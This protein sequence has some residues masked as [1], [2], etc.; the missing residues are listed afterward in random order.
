MS[1]LGIY[2]PEMVSPQTP[3]LTSDTVLSYFNPHK[4]ATIIV[5][6]SPVTLVLVLFFAKTTM[7][8]PMQVVLS[9]L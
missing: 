1:S 9:L 3:R 7:L 2:S 5:D 8:L 6:A 4:E